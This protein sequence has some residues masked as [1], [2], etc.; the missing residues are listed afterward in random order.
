MED[1]NKMKTKNILCIYPD[2]PSKEKAAGHKHAYKTIETLAEIGH[3]I[4]VLSFNT[5]GIVQEDYSS[6]EKI[7]ENLIVI[8]LS[9]W[10]K[11]INCLLRPWLPPLIASRIDKRFS[12]KLDELINN[13]DAIHVEFSQM[14]Y[15][16]RY[17]KIK[18]LNKNIYF[19]SHDIISQKTFREAARSYFLNPVKTLIWIST[20]I[21]E[22]Y[23]LKFC[24]KIIVFCEKDKSLLAKSKIPIKIIPLYTDSTKIEFDTKPK[25]RIA[26]FGALNRKENYSA[27]ID[28]IH[29]CWK[30]IIKSYPDLE[31]YVIGQKPPASVKEWNGKLNIKVTGFMD[32]PYKE[33]AESMVSIAPIKLGAG[34]KVKVLESLM[35][36]C[37]V[38]AFPAGAEGI[39]VTSEHGLI[40]TNNYH[41]MQK[42]IIMIIESQIKYERN[43]I[44]DFVS[45]KYNWN[46]AINHFKV[47]Y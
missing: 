40:I 25:K 17:L 44:R 34:L 30:Y 3:T 5:T 6:L 28:F 9:P 8:K 10:K 39:D 19:Y 2:L 45:A 7:C 15:Y 31:F 14:L 16:L 33:I 38:V 11:A 27:V 36:D 35:C 24:N 22:P 21:F 18:N 46:Q 4:H 42:K 26:F 41:E 37:P 20:K 12:E 29:H 43:S 23:F 1:I 32:D 13:C 47:E